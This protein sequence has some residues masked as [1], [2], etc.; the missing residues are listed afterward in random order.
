MDGADEGIATIK[1]E[2]TQDGGTR[3]RTEKDGSNDDIS[4]TGTAGDT[5]TGT[6]CLGWVKNESP[7][8]KVYRWNCT[9][10]DRDN[11]AAIPTNISNHLRK[12][13][14]YKAAVKLTD[15]VWMLVYDEAPTSGIDGDGAQYAGPGSLYVDYANAAL[16]INA[17]TSTMPNWTAV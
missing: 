4:F 8:A 14:P 7:K 13:D 16:Y 1:L 12:T 5:L 17:R 10:F 2:Y 9:S 11:S 15:D 3:W 6:V